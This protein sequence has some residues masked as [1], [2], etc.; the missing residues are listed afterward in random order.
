M[1]IVMDPSLSLAQDLKFYEGPKLGIEISWLSPSL[2]VKVKHI[3]G[4]QQ[5]IEIIISKKKQMY[6]GKVSTFTKL[7]NMARQ[8][9]MFLAMGLPFK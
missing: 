3:F 9:I 6:T 8:T 4:Q 7:S 5:Y 1:K 2:Y